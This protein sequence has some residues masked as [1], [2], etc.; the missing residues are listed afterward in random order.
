MSTK[1]VSKV[2]LDCADVNKLRWLPCPSHSPNVEATEC[3]HSWNSLIFIHNGAC[4]ACHR[5]GHTWNY[6][7]VE[8][9]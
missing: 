1:S 2:C 9:N 3:D 7:T 5:C 4:R 8:E 6:V